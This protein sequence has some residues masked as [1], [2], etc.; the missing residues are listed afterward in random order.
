MIND[1]NHRPLI[2]VST[3]EVRRA[4]QTHPSPQSDPQ[5]RELALGMT[6]LEAVERAG[7]VPVILAPLC[8]AGTDALL[9]KLD[10]LLLSGGP[11]ISP[12][13]Y[14]A[15]PHP[16][17]GPTEPDLDAFELHLARRARLRGVPLLGVCRGMQ[18][19]NVARGGTLVQHLPDVVGDGVRHR[20]TEP[21][22]VTTHEVH[23]QPHTRL[24]YLTGDRPT[25][26]VNSLHH[27]AIERLGDGLRPVAWS[28]DGLIEAVEAPLGPFVMGV[29]WHAEC[30]NRPEQTAL[31]EALVQAAAGSALGSSVR[32]A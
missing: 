26:P 18:L 6:Y 8:A 9:D 14:G 16:Q 30:L 17:L 13:T 11:D 27:Q 23:V 1:M 12:A 28:P 7:G 21:G 15:Q 10:G 19:L 31:F 20:Q 4:D 2:G 24:A 32:A 22:D 25:L 5:R 29:Q 3:S